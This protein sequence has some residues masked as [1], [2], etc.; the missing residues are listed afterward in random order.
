MGAHPDAIWFEEGGEG[1]GLR[2]LFTSA[3]PG[4]ITA[5]CHHGLVPSRPR[6]I[7]AWCHQGLVPSLPGAITAWCHEG[8]VP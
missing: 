4:A 6:A 7:T 3:L 8:L 1:G 5:W 2:C